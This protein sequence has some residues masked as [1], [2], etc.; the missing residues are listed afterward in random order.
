MSSEA[1]TAST[2]AAPAAAAASGSGGGGSTHLSLPIYS[3]NL[4]SN[5]PDLL[6]SVERRGARVDE[7]DALI[8]NLP[9]RCFERERE[10]EPSVMKRER[11][12]ERERERE[13]ENKKK[14]I[15]P[16]SLFLSLSLSFSLF[17]SLISS[18]SVISLHN[19]PS[20]S[21]TISLSL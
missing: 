5:D 10:R 1:S 20:L 8:D 2:A 14:R 16:F 18:L 9:V 15:F 4:D 21:L 3:L 11:E 7:I 13:R 12:K 6:T 19:L 17:L